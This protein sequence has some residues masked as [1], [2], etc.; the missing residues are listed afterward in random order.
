MP[1]DLGS[2]TCTTMMI[3]GYERLNDTSVSSHGRSHELCLS[4]GGD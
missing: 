2:S 4:H 1:L 3:E